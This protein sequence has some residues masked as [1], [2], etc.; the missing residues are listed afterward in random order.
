[1]VAAIVVM[2]IIILTT[3]NAK[4]HPGRRNGWYFENVI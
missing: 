1:M 4:V 3:K 2:E